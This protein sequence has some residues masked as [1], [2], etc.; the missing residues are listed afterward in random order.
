MHMPV[1]MA[2]NRNFSGIR[3]LSQPTNGRSA[4]DTMD[5]VQEDHIPRL[6]SMPADSKMD[7]AWKLM[8]VM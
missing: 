6:R 2:I 5:G 3:S 4:T 8:P 1:I 7:A